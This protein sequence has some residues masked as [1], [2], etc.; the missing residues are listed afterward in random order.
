MNTV[1]S[2]IPIEKD[3]IGLLLTDTRQALDAIG[4][5]IDPDCFLDPVCRAV[6]ETATMLDAKGPWTSA[7]VTQSLYATGDLDRIGGSAALFAL[8][9]NAPPTATMIPAYVRE[10]TEARERRRLARICATL[11]AQASDMGT[12]L[13]SALATAQDALIGIASAGTGAEPEHIAKILKGMESELLRTEPKTG[14]MLSG[15]LAIDG[16]VRGFW[17]GQMVVVAARPSVGKSTLL[18][19]IAHNMA[20]QGFPT[21]LVTLEMTAAE[22]V[23]RMTVGGA[24]V[25]LVDHANGTHN[26]GHRAA[27][28][29]RVR[30]MAG[31]PLWLHDAAGASISQLRATVRA[32]VARH[33]IAVVLVDYLQLVSAKSEDRRVE[34][35]K[36]SRGLKAMAKESGV[37]TIAAAQLGRT[38]DSGDPKLSHLRES[39]DIEQDADIVCLM[40]RNEDVDRDGD[41]LVNISI[42]KHR[43][44]PVGRDEI[45]FQPQFCRFVNVQE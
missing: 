12:P 4:G 11:A 41:Y 25:P 22:I 42:A 1:P 43:G 27:I 29:D 19:G 23:T 21:L 34:V 36:V 26:R 33:K 14:G 15:F 20:V 35:G 39:G 44:G 9:E 32:M 2:A 5:K 8:M 18:H 24:N 28:F 6:W 7:M 3:L 16:I 40:W 13:S 38:G 37:V 31:I 10:L 17:R 30:K 45:L